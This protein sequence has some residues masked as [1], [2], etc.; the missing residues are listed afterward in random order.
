MPTTP[1][2]KAYICD[3]LCEG[4]TGGVL[5]RKRMGQGECVRRTKLDSLWGSSLVRSSPGHRGV[6]RP[7][8][9]RLEIQK[10]EC[11]E[12]PQV[13]C[14][15]SQR[16]R[17]AVRAVMKGEKESV[18]DVARSTFIISIILSQSKWYKAGL[19][20]I[21]CRNLSFI[22]QGL[23][24]FQKHHGT[25]SKYQAVFWCD[26]F[27]IIRDVTVSSISQ[28]KECL[29]VKQSGAR[30]E[31]PLPS[32]PCVPIILCAQLSSTNLG[33]EWKWRMPQVVPED[34]VTKFVKLQM[35]HQVLNL[36]CGNLFGFHVS[37]D[38]SRK[39]DKVTDKK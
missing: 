16:T 3:T 10:G 12:G 30:W 21:I 23:S 13:W 2:I 32:Q 29:D 38:E 19:S 18:I 15:D 25:T 11:P 22:Q 1:D 8:S 5:W 27:Q 33:A 20:G 4:V 6:E 14:C 24:S 31:L 36:T 39:W 28:R 9:E 34:W 26:F 17:A 37:R 7:T 35:R